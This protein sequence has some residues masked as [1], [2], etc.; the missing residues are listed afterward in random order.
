VS[1]RSLRRGWSAALKTGETDKPFS[2]I[3]KE[4]HL[5][6]Y[7]SK[8]SSLNR[9]DASR[10]TSCRVAPL[11]QVRNVHQDVRKAEQR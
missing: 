11:S 7:T 6:R 3:V 10:K 4:L 5:S 9:G 8:T 2:G 1:T